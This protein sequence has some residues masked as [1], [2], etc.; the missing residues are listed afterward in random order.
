MT[1]KVNQKTKKEIPELSIIPDPAVIPRFVSG[2]GVAMGR[3]VFRLDFT[4]SIEEKRFLIGSF[5]LLPPVAKKLY[6][7]LKEAISRYEEEYGEIVIE[8]EK[9]TEEEVTGE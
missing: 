3:E 2:F 4:S 5:V 1:E 8:K 7:A 9:F 6:E